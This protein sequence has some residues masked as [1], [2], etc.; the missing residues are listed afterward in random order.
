MPRQGYAKLSN[1]LWLNEKAND[2]IDENP[3]AFAMWTLAISYCSD[4]LNDGVLS[5]RALRRIGAD[6]QDVAD[7]V[8]FGMLDDLGD[9]TYQIHDY[10]KHQNSRE[11]VEG[12]REKDRS[13]KASKSTSRV[14]TEPADKTEDEPETGRDGIQNDSARNPDGIQNDSLGLN[15]NQN[16]ESSNEDSLPLPPHGG[17]EREA[18]TDRDYTLEFEQFWQAY[19]RHEG[20]RR[21]FDQFRKARRKTRLAI[22][23]AKATAYGADPNREPGYTLTAANWLAGEHWDDDPLPAKPAKAAAGA[24]ARP[25]SSAANLAANAALIARLKAE[26][27]QN[28]P[29]DG[30]N[31][32]RRALMPP[33][34]R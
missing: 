11:E 25:G 4:E 30:P 12:K 27:S 8:R 14:A 7:L 18:G 10:L 5:K 22:L 21:A 17:R 26:E 3:H 31:G 20:K 32:P 16:Q 1:G 13:R 29:S 15:Q 34:P 6:R 19:P 33:K 24:R 28:G 23:I 2:L 9:G